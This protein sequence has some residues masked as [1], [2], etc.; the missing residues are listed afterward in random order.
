MSL[1]IKETDFES[2]L[3]DISLN[4]YTEDDLLSFVTIYERAFLEDLLGV[5]L[6]TRLINDLDP[7]TGLPQDPIFQGIFEPF[8]KDSGGQII[9]SKGIKFVLSGL[10]WSE[11]VKGQNFKNTISGKVTQNHEVATL[12]SFINGQYQETVNQVLDSF[13][14]I[15][16]E[17]SSNRTDFPD[18]NGQ[19][20]EY[21]SFL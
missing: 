12:V 2:G 21:L 15:Q 13:K 16:T 6:S 14:A 19:N 17:V 18:F 5:D 4:Q 20:F 1:I 9:R 10:V 3:F 7:S 8:S 11:Y